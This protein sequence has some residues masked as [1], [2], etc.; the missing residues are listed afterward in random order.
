M[1]RSLVYSREIRFY[2]VDFSRYATYHRKITRNISST[3]SSFGRHCEYFIWLSLNT[4][5]K[6]KYSIFLKQICNNIDLHIIRRNISISVRKEIFIAE[7][8]RYKIGNWKASALLLKS[9]RIPYSRCC[10]HS[11]IYVCNDSELDQEE[12]KTNQAGRSCD[13]L[14]SQWR[15]PLFGLFARWIAPV[16]RR[17]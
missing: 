2:A 3:W 7:C 10:T 8:L 17:T 16:W 4:C 5:L 13:I 12:A 15:W 9:K 14:Q 1:F 6:L 11:L